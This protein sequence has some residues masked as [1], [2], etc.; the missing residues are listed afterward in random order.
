MTPTF[1]EFEQGLWQKNPDGDVRSTYDIIMFH[2][3]NY[4]DERDVPIT[5]DKIASKYSEYLDWHNAKYSGVEERYIVKEER[6]R[7]IAKFVQ[8]DYYKRTFNSVTFFPE[9]DP[10]LFGEEG[11]NELKKKHDRFKERIANARNKLT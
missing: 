3:D 9:R 10:Y 8:D 7:T 5:F 2:V 1:D 4:Y 6:K 11:L